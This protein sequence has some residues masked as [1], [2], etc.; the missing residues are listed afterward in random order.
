M[1]APWGKKKKKKPRQ[2]IKKQR[3]HFA[4]RSP[5]SQSCGFSSGYGWMVSWIIRTAERWRIDAFELWCCRRLLRVPWTERRSNQWFPKEINPKGN[6]SSG[7]TMLKLKLQSFGTWCEEVT[8]WRRPWCWERLKAGGEGDNRGW[9]GGMASP[10]Q[11]TWVWATPGEGEGQ[12]S[13]VCSSPSCR[14]ESGTTEQLNNKLK[15]MV[16]LK[17]FWNFFS[18]NWD[19]TSVIMRI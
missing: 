9:D 18:L 13:L 12:G 5:S 10:T 1:L 11:W 17:Y 8:H 15:K 3:L 19:S 2:H 16:L 4:D 6:Q 7:G 14:K